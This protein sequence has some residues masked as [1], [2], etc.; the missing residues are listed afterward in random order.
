MRRR[1]G[2]RAAL[3]RQ[4]VQRRRAAIGRVLPVR[5]TRNTAVDRLRFARH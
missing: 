3:F 2:E 1:H 5:P 4:M